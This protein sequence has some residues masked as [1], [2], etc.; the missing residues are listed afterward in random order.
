MGDLEKVEGNEDYRRR[1]APRLRI[2]PVDVTWVLEIG[3]RGDH[4]GVVDLPGRI[5]EV[6]I[7]GAQI[8][9]PAEPRFPS[10]ARVPV[11]VRGELSIVTVRRALASDRPD[12]LRYGVEFTALGPELEAHLA[13]FLGLGRPTEGLWLRRAQ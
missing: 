2:E 11:R 4:P 5:L 7:S 1:I 9:G 10:D 3:T 12:L 13:G 8:E 6:S